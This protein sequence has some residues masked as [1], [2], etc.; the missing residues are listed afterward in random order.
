MTKLVELETLQKR[1]GLSTQNE[2]NGGQKCV[3]YD[4]VKDKRRNDVLGVWLP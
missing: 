1:V 3:I 2:N 4:L